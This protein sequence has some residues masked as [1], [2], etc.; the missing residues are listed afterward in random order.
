MKYAAAFVV[1]IAGLAWA[2]EVDPARLLNELTAANKAKDASKISSLLKGIAEVGSTSKDQKAVDA[3]AKELG[4]S[5]KACKGNW[6]TLR[7]IADTLGEL[8]SKNAISSLKRY[9][10]QKKAKDENHESIQIRALL[11]MG[12]MADSRQIDAIGDQCKNRKVP[13]A[14]AAYEAFKHYATAK[15]K[16]R[17]RCAEIL[18]KRLE[19]E[20]P[21]SGGQQSGGQVSQEAQERWQQLQQVIVAS[22]QAVCREPTIND[23]ENWREWWKEN[24]RRSSA[25]KDSA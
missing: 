11:A 5:F 22:M 6:G 18:M 9:A 17:K 4:K 19:A 14:K 13:I 24:K 20:Y 15:G 7:E 23:V 21:S 1:F 8:R 3:L 10:Y 12:K 16:V 25:W 2:E